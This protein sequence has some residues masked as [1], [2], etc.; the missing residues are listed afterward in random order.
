MKMRSARKGMNYVS[1]ELMR[2]R[3]KAGFSSYGER[4]YMEGLEDL[5]KRKRLVTH[6]CHSPWQPNLALCQISSTSALETLSPFAR[7]GE[8]FEGTSGWTYG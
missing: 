2:A 4:L 7:A 8:S 1:A 3:D 6:P 5:E